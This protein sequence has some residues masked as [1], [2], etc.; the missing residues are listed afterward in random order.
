MRILI[1]EDE[2]LERKAMRKFIETN[3]SEM[4]IVGEAENGRK[5]IKLATELSPDV[6]FMDIKM[7][8]ISGLEAIEKINADLPSI[9]FILVSAY[10]SF[11]YAKQAMQFGIKEYILK[12]GKKEEI[13]RA[14]L[15]VKKEIE[16]ETAQSKEKIQSD[17]LVK[18][19]FITKIIQNPT[20]NSVEE[21]QRQ[22]YP[23]LKSGCFLVCTFS[24]SFDFNAFEQTL[25]KNLDYSYI[26]LHAE[27]ELSVCVL[28]Q[29]VVEKAE[30][31]IITRKIVLDT[32]GI[33]YIGI[34]FPYTRIDQLGKSYQE[35]YSACF[36]LAKEQNSNYGFLKQS[37]QRNAAAE[38]IAIV[39]TE[40]GKG[41]NVLAAA[42]FKENASLFTA[43]EK[44]NLYIEIKNLVTK[45]GIAIPE[46]SIASLK[47]IRDWETFINI[48][49]IR[50]NEYYQSRQYIE[51]A[52]RYIENNYNT[53]ITLEETAT[54]VNLSANYFSNLFKQEIGET[55]ID[56]VTKIR[57]SRAKELMEEH[58]YSLK[59]ISYMV[60]YKDP[61]Y[62]SR[63]FKKHFNDSP[64]RFQQEI[65]KK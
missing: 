9:K 36:Q 32:K 3:F 38:T 15:R 40:L 41:N 60:G 46:N 4:T 23:D 28:A 1:V 33:V 42:Y 65:F 62:F 12:P 30:L 64:K 31:L 17:Q 39:L 20:H 5:A 2:L 21:T 59:E 57:L 37:N 29:N 55:F 47:S 13:V 8:G 45:K 56:Y 10:D 52:K 27:N 63:V 25:E 35:A 44:E 48:C 26:T 54:H 11:E 51:Q 6:I 43:M 34:G 53:T 16:A 50:I 19:R 49:C 22:L 18:E 14:L 7:P 58:S 24:G 61:N